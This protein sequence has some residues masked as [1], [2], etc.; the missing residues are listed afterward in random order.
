MS[1]ILENTAT[2]TETGA[3]TENTAIEKEAAAEASA[4]ISSEKNAEAPKRGRGTVTMII[5]IV[6]TVLMLIAFA[7]YVW[8]FANVGL[9]Q[10]QETEGWE[11]FGVGIGMA[12]FL[13]FSVIAGIAELPFGIPALILSIVTATRG[14]GG[15]RTTGIVTLILNAVALLS[16]VVSFIVFLIVRGG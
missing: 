6:L 16:T 10:G 7:A 8:S 9:L 14:K 2:V 3:A 15:V 4:E 5:G 13:I 11:G 1:E 12:V